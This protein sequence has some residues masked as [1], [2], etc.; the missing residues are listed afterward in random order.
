MTECNLP[1]VQKTGPMIQIPIRQVGVENVEV[2]FSLQCKTGGYQQMVANVSMRANLDANTKGVSM[3]RF[4]RT[5]KDY[6]TL[7]LKHN[8][9]LQILKDLRKNLEVNESYMTFKFKMPIIRRSIKS[10]HEFPMYHDCMFEGHFIV[11]ENGEEHFR[12]FQGVRVQ[13]AS[14]CPCS[15]E[16]CNHLGEGFP[17]AQRS[18]TNIVVE[19]DVENKQKM[20]LEDLIFAVEDSIHTL[21]YPIIKRE[22]EQEIARIAGKNPIF[23]EDAI[24]AISFKIDSMTGVKDWVIKCIHEESIHS[25][26]A[27][28]VNYKGIPGGF[29]YRY[30]L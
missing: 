12:F 3:S 24:R 30:F 10:N 1:D 14:Y 18:F 27:I 19:I 28:A 8:L 23:V 26:E 2:P 4:I 29:D 17:H 7:P 5:L 13:Y 20:W 21:P 15:A 6:L 22:D 9:C 25:S 16:L 11:D